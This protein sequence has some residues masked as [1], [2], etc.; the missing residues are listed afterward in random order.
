MYRHA[1]LAIMLLLVP[2]CFILF[3]TLYGPYGDLTGSPVLKRFESEQELTEY[4]ADQ[5][6]AR[7]SRM[8]AAPDS[9]A[10]VLGDEGDGFFEP[11]GGESAGPS[12]D[13]SDVAASPP[14]GPTAGT[15]GDA[16]G[17]QEPFS[18]TTIQEFG[19]DEADVVKTD[20]KSYVVTIRPEAKKATVRTERP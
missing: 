19:V 17:V 16:D 18:E 13:D 4:F 3:P 20:G 8:D 10:E 14:P 15:G 6:G 1:T 12:Q 9:P 2:G 7:N 11:R 5:I